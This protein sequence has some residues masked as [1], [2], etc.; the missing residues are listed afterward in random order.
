MGFNVEVP[1]GATVSFGQVS[2]C[3]LKEIFKRGLSPHVFPIGQIDTSAFK[4]NEEFDLWLNSC[5]Q[6]AKSHYKRTNPTFRLWHIDGSESS[7]SNNQILFTFHEPDSATETETNIV[8]NQSKVLFSSQ[9]SRDVFKTFGCENVDNLPLG[10]DADS[11]HRIENRQYVDSGVIQ[12]G[13][14]GKA[15]KRKNHM[16]IINL[17]VKKYGNNPKFKLNCALYNPFLPMDV[18]NNM[19]ANA[20]EGKHYWN[21]NF[22]PYMQDN[23]AYNDFLN[24]NCGM[25]DLSSAEGWSLPTFQT[26]CL[27]GH[28]L[29][30]NATGLKDWVDSE[31]A[32]LVNPTGKI[33]LYDGVFFREGHYANQGSGFDWKDEQFYEGMEKLIAR[34]EQNPVNEAGLKLQEQFTYEKTVDQIIKELENV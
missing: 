33:L 23:A 17:W 22:N 24:S 18:Q 25:I 14:A 34:I 32:V 10:F 1:L 8:K 28:I 27:G 9:Y 26:A 5:V 21:V 16:R 11:F 13:L 7:V 6:K 15:E 12:F 20:M 29:A 31:N 19:V 4:K 2:Y 3:I 30:L